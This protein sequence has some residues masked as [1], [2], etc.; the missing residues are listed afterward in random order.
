MEETREFKKRWMGLAFLC[1]SLFVIAVDNT[2]LNLA[3]PSISRELGSSASE[4]QWIVDAYVLV[5]ASLLLTIGAISDRIGRKK[6]LMGGLVFFGISSLIAALSTSTEMLI[7][8]RALMGIGA[9]T[10]MPSTLSVLTA[11]FRKPKE[12][13]KAIALWAGTFPLG[14]GLGP[15]IGGLLLEHFD[16]NSI[17]YI[18]IPIVIIA[19]LGGYFLIMDSKDE[20]ARRI[21]FAGAVLSIVGFFALV[22]GII[23]AGE[24]GW[25]AGNVLVSF[26]VAVVLLGVFAW[27][28]VR[29]SNAMLPLHF[30]KNM[31]FTGANVAMTLVMFSL[32]GTVFF[33]SQYFQ[34]VLGYSPLKAGACLLPIALV[35]PPAA[36]MSAPLAQR[37][38]TKMTVA[39]GILIASVGLFYLSQVSEVD[40]PYST[41]LIGLC[42]QPIG[43]G[44]TMSPATNS[45]MGS[46]PIDKAGIGSAMNDTTRQ[47]GGA[48]GVAI[49]GT[50]MNSAYISQ[51]E[52]SELITQVPES[53]VEPIKA[54]IQSAHIVAQNIA[55]PGLSQAIVNLSSKAFTSGMVDA[56]IVGGIIMA[57]AAIVTLIILP[58]RI[59]GPENK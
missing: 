52:T 51:I 45:I 25:D 10:I 34:S 30:F 43:L 16:W 44:L 7:V 57:T 18:N 5:F 20:Q 24:D 53:L 31:S 33:I 55:D 6:V 27:W 41:L 1:I 54:S 19:L 3:L 26:G 40:T 14:A 38:G 58:S 17:F 47:I 28:E 9:A 48:L 42:I 35:S 8:M 2:V 37:I 11:T 50:I 39:I 32:F 59:R 49:L 56:M 46:V 29:S 4:L 12:R 23:Q 15:L 21:D 22:Y 36:I 13:A